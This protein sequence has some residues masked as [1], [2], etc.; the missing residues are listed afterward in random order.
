MLDVAERCGPGLGVLAHPAVVDEPDRD[1]V[2]EVQLLAAASPGHDQ[3]GLLEQ[4]QVLHDAEARHREAAREG[5][6]R[7]PVLAEELVEQGAPRRVGQRAE[8]VVHGRNNM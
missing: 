6:R 5:A 4:L 3:A 8:H 7:L 2:Q 1:G